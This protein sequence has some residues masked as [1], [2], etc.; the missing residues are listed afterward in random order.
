MRSAESL[1]GTILRPEKRQKLIRLGRMMGLS[2]FDSNLVIAIVQD[3]A[4]RGYAPSYCPGAGEK[5]LAMVPLPRQRRSPRQTFN[6]ISA[7]VA[8]VG[9]EVLLLW[10]LLLG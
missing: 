10:W 1:E 9:M 4:R 3:Q 8:T 6:I 2:L 7:V 5:Q